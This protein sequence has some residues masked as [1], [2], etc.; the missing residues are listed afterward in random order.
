VLFLPDV[1]P[2]APRFDAG[3][4]FDR[5]L[6]AQVDRRQRLG[7]PGGPPAGGEDIYEVVNS[8]PF[9]GEWYL[10]IRFATPTVVRSFQ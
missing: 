9:E 2:F 6:D 1:R 10:N 4:P 5:F 7:Q 3:H 8:L